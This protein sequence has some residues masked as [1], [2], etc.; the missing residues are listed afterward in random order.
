M[1]VEAI[2]TLQLALHSSFTLHLLDVLYVPYIQ[3]NLISIS[4]LD[5]DG[6]SCTFGN[7]MCVMEIQFVM[8]LY[9]ISF[10]YCPKVKS[11]D[12]CKRY[13]S[14]AQER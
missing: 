10:I 9:M 7:S 6:Y 3:I 8:H 12:E 2:G 1:E 11:L 13:Q 14:E 5:R 4:K